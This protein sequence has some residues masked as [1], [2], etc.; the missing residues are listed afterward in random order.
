MF[1]SKS[2]ELRAKTS[3]EE[4]TL[5]GHIGTEPARPDLTQ[6]QPDLTQ[7]QSGLS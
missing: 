4:T 2:A 6:T 7:T 3:D 5:N 1:L